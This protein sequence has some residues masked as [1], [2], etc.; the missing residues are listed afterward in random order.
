MA[1]AIYGIW[2][3]TRGQIHRESLE[4]RDKTARVGGRFHILGEAGHADRSL[5]SREEKTRVVGRFHILG[6]AAGV[7]RK[8]ILTLVGFT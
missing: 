8:P 3:T 4:S 2:P 1:S 5:E 6:E 7:D